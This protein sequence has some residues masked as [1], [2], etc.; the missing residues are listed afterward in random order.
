MTWNARFTA[1]TRYD[2]D[3][4]LIMHW[5]GRALKRL[6]TGRYPHLQSPKDV[7]IYGNVRIS[8]KNASVAPISSNAVEE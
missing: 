5:M 1:G 7:S 2:F 8:T 6:D 4:F 3:I